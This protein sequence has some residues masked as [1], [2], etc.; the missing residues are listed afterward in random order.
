MARFDNAWDDVQSFFSSLAGVGEA[1]LPAVLDQNEQLAE[2]AGVD[3]DVYIAPGDGHTIL[4]RPGLY[5]L[6]VEGTAFVD[7]LTTLVE[8]GD[9]GDVRCVDCQPPT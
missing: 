3:L 8:G 5:D 7:W 4:G 6:E 2:D 1:G 9:P